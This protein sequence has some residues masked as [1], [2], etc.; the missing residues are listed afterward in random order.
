MSKKVFGKKPK[1]LLSVKLARP[2]NKGK[3]WVIFSGGF[4]IPERFGIGA[5]L[6][7]VATIILF[8]VPDAAVAKEFVTKVFDI[9]EAIWKLRPTK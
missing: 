1:E 9:V 3:Y 8:N 4:P 2:S 7:I 6:V 5:T